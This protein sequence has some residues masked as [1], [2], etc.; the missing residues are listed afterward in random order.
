MSHNSESG[1]SATRR[2]IDI[3]GAERL[4]H[5]SY[6]SE[7]GRNTGRLFGTFL[8][9]KEDFILA[10]LFPDRISVNPYLPGSDH[11]HV[12]R[13]GHDVEYMDLRDAVM[14]YRS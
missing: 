13:G 6:K 11:Y 2:F 5:G 9:G 12:F 10:G 7:R 1:Q 4:D 14:G 3:I 8:S